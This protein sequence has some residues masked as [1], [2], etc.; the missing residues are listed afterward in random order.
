MSMQILILPR[1]LLL[2]SDGSSSFMVKTMISLL[3]DNI[4]LFVDETDFSYLKK[5]SFWEIFF[6]QNLFT[7]G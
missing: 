2:I 1:M 7:G 6:D 4:D 5:I 3:K